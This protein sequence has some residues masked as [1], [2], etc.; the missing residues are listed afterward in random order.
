MSS[1]LGYS[2]RPELLF[3]GFPDLIPLTAFPA[4]PSPHLPVDRHSDL[5]WPLPLWI[6]SS[7]SKSQWAVFVLLPDSLT[8]QPPLQ[9]H[10]LVFLPALSGGQMHLGP[11]FPAW[12]FDPCLCDKGRA[13]FP[14]SSVSSTEAEA[15]EEF[16]DTC[17]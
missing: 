4:P 1:L 5:A 6:V 13:S 2:P 15:Q 8:S 12:L 10:G 7:T 14:L 17:E 9:D 16:G 11:S 3:T